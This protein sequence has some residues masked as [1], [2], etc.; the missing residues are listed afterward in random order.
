MYERAHG[1]NSALGTDDFTGRT[2]AGITISPTTTINVTGGADPQATGDHV[3]KGQ[4]GINADII[5]NS[6]AT[7]R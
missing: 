3:L 1:Y 7:V 6:G 4:A 5:R 2:A